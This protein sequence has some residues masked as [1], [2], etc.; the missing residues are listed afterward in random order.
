ML[1]S[2]Q[3]LYKKYFTKPEPL[4]PGI[5]HYQAPQDADFPYRLHL[6]IEQN[7]EGVLILNAS[8]VLHLNQT[9]V[10]YA[11]HLIQGDADEPTAEEIARRFQ[12]SIL[13][14][15]QDYRAF[16]ERLLTLITTPDLDPISYLGFERED[17][18]G[19]ELSAPLRLDCALTYHTSQKSTLGAPGERVTRDL[20][21]DEWKQIIDTAWRAGIPHLIF[22][23]G[24]PTLRPDLPDLIAYAESLGMVTGVLSDGLRFTDKKYFQNVLNAG[25]DHLMLVLDPSDE[26]SWEALRDSIAADIHVTVHLT[27]TE[28]NK[29]DLPHILQ[30]LAGLGVK[31]LSLSE[32]DI[33]LSNDLRHARELAAHLLIPLV[34]DLPVPYSHLNPVELELRDQ[35]QHIPGAGRAWLYVEPDGDVLPGQGINVVLGNILQDPWDQIWANARQHAPAG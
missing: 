1:N 9:A 29:D 14:A 7:G 17:L 6:R 15:L 32:N 30:R 4:P 34:W 31:A 11:Y 33:R 35:G 28:K 19:V 16:K 12:I 23:G 2:I 27:I 18:H 22:T 21:C 25:L 3:K 8:T 24:E 20:D 10:E 5:Y 26:Q 13:Q